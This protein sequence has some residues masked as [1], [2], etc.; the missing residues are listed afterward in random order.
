MA[1]VAGLIAA[2]SDMNSLNFAT[3]MLCFVIRL[4]MKWCPTFR[5][6]AGRIAV[7]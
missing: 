5:P 3:F 6:R 2:I 4:R 1:S 7:C